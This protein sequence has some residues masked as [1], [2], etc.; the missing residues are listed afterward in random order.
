MITFDEVGALLDDIADELPEGIYRE[1]NGGIML[2]PDTIYD[3]ESDDRD[4]LYILGEYHEDPYGLGRYIAIYYGSFIKVYGHED[5]EM[6][7]EM[8]QELLYHELLHHL[9]S[10]A[11]EQGLELQ[12]AVEFAEYKEHLKK[13]DNQ[14]EKP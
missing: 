5:R 14:R 6:Q 10:L 2:L 12:D 1:L 3:P 4:P 8:L 13:F 7:K 9:E 11:G